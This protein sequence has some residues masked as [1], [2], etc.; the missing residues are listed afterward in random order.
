M[1]NNILTLI[2]TF[3]IT[4]GSFAQTKNTDSLTTTKHYLGLHAGVTTGYG[5]SYRYWPQKLGFQVTGIPIFGKDFYNASLGLSA[6]YLLKD[7]NKV[8][9]YG[10]LGNH[11][12]FDGYSTP[13]YDNTGNITGTQKVNY[14]TYNIGVGIGF[15]VDFLDVLDFNLQ[16]GYAINNI[17]NSAYTGLAGEVGLYYHL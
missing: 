12:Q 8:D 1:K 6:L 15:K 9:L 7:N 5:F 16:T 13:T 11:F 4:I 14:T 3:L 17:T 10:Y 2:G